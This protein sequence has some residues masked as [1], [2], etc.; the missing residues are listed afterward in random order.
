VGVACRRSG[1]SQDAGIFR[2]F[3]T[4]SE[5]EQAWVIVDRT[6]EVLD[7]ANQI[8]GELLVPDAGPDQ[9]AARR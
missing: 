1:C 7:R 4:D 6:P 8:L 2:G 9:G 5:N 3:N